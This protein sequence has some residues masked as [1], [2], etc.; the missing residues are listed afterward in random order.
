MNNNEIRILLIE[1][2]EADAYFLQETVDSIFK[3]ELTWKRTLSDGIAALNEESCD[4]VLLDLSLPDSN[5][6]NSLESISKTAP[7]V[8]VVILTGLDDDETGLQALKEGA[9]DYLIKGKVT[10]DGINRSLRYAIERKR[11]EQ[12]LCEAAKRSQEAAACAHAVQEKLALALRSAGMGTWSWDVTTDTISLDR[13]AQQLFDNDGIQDYKSFIASVHED[14]RDKVAEAVSDC[15][16]QVTDYSMEY[17]II[18]PNGN[19]RWISAVGKTHCERGKVTTMSGVLRDVSARRL[20]EEVSRRC[21]LLE[22]REEFVAMLAHDLKGPLV[23]TVRILAAMLKGSVGA[24]SPAQHDLLGKICISHESLLLKLNNILDSYRLESNEQELICSPV[25]VNELVMP[26]LAEMTP[27]AQSKQINLVYDL[28]SMPNVSAD[29]TAMQRVVSNLLSN[30]IKYTA[31]G[32]TI[33]LE[34]VHQEDRALIRIADTGEGIAPEKITKLFDRFFQAKSHHSGN[35]WGL[36]LYLC[37]QLLQA[38]GGSITCTSEK[39]A[40]TTF[41][42]SLAYAAFSY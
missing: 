35:G 1:D 10:P 18:L 38:Q 33:N 26:A 16:A 2:C 21:A 20:Q 32:G 29:K 28:V 36:G 6:L 22:Q 30:A 9:Q 17:R 23:G 14:D 11:A 24:L 34:A 19:V 37:K 7:K 42:I 39:D 4:I 8:P 25:D 5:S 12:L 27:L 3:A 15:L 40:G 13:Q 31:V 41:E